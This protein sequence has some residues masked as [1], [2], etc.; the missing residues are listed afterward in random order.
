[1]G[2]TCVGRAPCCHQ[3]EPEDFPFLDEI[4]GHDDGELIRLNELSGEVFGSLV[5]ASRVDGG[6]RLTISPGLDGEVLDEWLE[7][8][9]RFFPDMSRNLIGDTTVELLGP[10]ALIH[11]L[12]D[13]LEEFL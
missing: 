8:G 3:L 7:L 12:E 2:V 4:G 10:P 5:G 6:F 9:Q 1:M 11:T 13:Q